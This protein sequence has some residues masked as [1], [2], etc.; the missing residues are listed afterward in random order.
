MTFLATEGAE[1]REETSFNKDIQDIQDK[2]GNHVRVKTKR[3]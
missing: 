2:T 1:N 3:L